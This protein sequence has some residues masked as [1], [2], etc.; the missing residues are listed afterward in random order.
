MSISPEMLAAYADD[1]LD[2]AER[3][4]VEQA[5][6]QDP[7]L[8]QEVATHRALRA[9]LVAHF[10]PILEETLPESLTRALKAPPAPQT[11]T[12]VSIETARARRREREARSP[13]PEPVSKAR[14]RPRWAVG[15]GIALAACVAL[16]VVIGRPA[17]V[18]ASNYAAPELA[19]ALDS[20]LSG[21][22][23]GSGPQVLLSFADATGAVCRGFAG[24]Q[25]SG[26]ACHDA[27]G[28]R[29]ERRFPGVTAQEGAYRQAGS[30]DPKLM[31]AMQDMAVGGALDPAAERAARARGWTAA[32]PPTSR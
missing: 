10:A 2:G 4:M 25:A 8:A 7:A 27:H 30:T 1:Q 29:L 22:Q 3:A 19:Q 21:E 26:I 5:L 20:R 24:S 28:W 17:I 14:A 15:A 18:P 31:A 11:A 12:V 6:A 16:A 23:G 13:N 32:P 9:R